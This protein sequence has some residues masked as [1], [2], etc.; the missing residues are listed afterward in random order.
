[1]TL[2][3]NFAT[4]PTPA[5]GQPWRYTN[6]T[7]LGPAEALRGARDAGLVDTRPGAPS[8][9]FRR[10]YLAFLLPGLV[11]AWAQHPPPWDAPRAVLS[12]WPPLLAGWR[13]LVAS[14]E[15]YPQREAEFF[16]RPGWRELLAAWA[17]PGSVPGP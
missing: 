1:M 16:G 14:T 15:D 7:W 8:A 9:A 13:A 17:G 10:L 12:Q 4:R 3:A 6:F 2:P 11:P 5:G